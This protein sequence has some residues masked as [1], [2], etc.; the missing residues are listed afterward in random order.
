MMFIK[1]SALSCQHTGNKACSCRRMAGAYVCNP[2]TFKALQQPLSQPDT[3]FLLTAPARF[4]A[5]EGQATP[6][7]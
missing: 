4:K 5:A 6:N 3:S 1:V 2:Q 7:D